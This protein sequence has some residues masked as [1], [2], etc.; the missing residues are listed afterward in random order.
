M[1]SRSYKVNDSITPDTIY[2]WDQPQLWQFVS[3]VL[4]YGEH[5]VCDVSY[6][7]DLRSAAALQRS[8]YT[9]RLLEPRLSYVLIADIGTT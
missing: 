6:K 5:T 9:S 1:H 8:R 2:F 4:Q 7:T 3:S